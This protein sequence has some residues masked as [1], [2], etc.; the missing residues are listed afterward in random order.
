M[1]DRYYLVTS[2][3][4]RNQLAA[5][6]VVLPMPEDI[7]GEVVIEHAHGKRVTLSISQANADDLSDPELLRRIRKT[8]VES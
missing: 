5:W 4:Q 8:I 2:L 1:R 7:S 3:L 6:H